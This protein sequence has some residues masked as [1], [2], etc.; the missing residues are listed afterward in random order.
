VSNAANPVIPGTLAA[1]LDKMTKTVAKLEKRQKKVEK[2]QQANDLLL[3]AS[4]DAWKQK[5][6]LVRAQYQQLRQNNGYMLPQPLQPPQ[7]QP[8]PPQA[9]VPQTSWQM[10]RQQVQVQK[11]QQTPAQKTFSISAQVDGRGNEITKVWHSIL[12]LQDAGKQ[13]EALEVKKAS[14]QALQKQEAGYLWNSSAYEELGKRIAQIDVAL[15]S[16][17]ANAAQ[18]AVAGVSLAA[19]K[20][21]LVEEIIA[22]AP[23]TASYIPMSE[24]SI[25]TDVDRDKNLEKFIAEI[26]SSAKAELKALKLKKVDL[27]KDQKQKVRYL[28]VRWVLS[29]TDGYTRLQADIESTKTQISD[30]KKRIDK[31]A[32]AMK[33]VQNNI[34]HLEKNLIDMYTAEPNVAPGVSGTLMERVRGKEISAAILSSKNGKALQRIEDLMISKSERAKELTEER[35][36]L[37]EQRPLWRRF[38]IRMSWGKLA[39]KIATKDKELAEIKADFEACNTAYVSISNRVDSL[40]E[41]LLDNIIAQKYVSDDQIIAGGSDDEQ[42]LKNT[43]GSIEDEIAQKTVKPAGWEAKL[44]KC[45][46]ARSALQNIAITRI[47]K[48]NVAP[49]PSWI[50][51]YAWVRPQ[52]AANVVKVAKVAI[53][54]AVVGKFFGWF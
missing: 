37:N 52:T 17:T 5:Q 12:G 13:R 4:Q 39:Q 32:K 49:A 36:K 21:Q 38:P 51:P 42:Q 19:L 7:Q 2:K 16:A 40:K 53:V 23:T 33:S 14:L 48:A 11:S 34:R 18:S 46:N 26:H 1:K 24:E 9:P 25:I 41:K 22:L 44:Q 10:P 20:D 6:D 15:A 43:I 54:V 28:P 3:Q 8:Q 30:Q 31:C 35:K 50:S 29:P 27:Q 47:K 45:E